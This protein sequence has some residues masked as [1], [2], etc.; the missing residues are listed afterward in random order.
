MKK[1]TRNKLQALRRSLEKP[2]EKVKLNPAYFILEIQRVAEEADQKR[3]SVLVD[4][5]KENYPEIYETILVLVD[6]PP[7]QAIAA[8]IEQWPALIAVKL[9]PDH[10]RVIEMIQNE[11]KQRRGK[12]VQNTNS[13][14]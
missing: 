5:F 1:K 8:L 12:N 2:I 7:A 9:Y 13:V 14:H 11:I 6:T 10:E 4:S 3:L